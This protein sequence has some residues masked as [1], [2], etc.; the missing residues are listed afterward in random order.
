[1]GTVL[2]IALTFLIVNIIVD[3]LIAFI[4]P[5]IRLFDEGRLMIRSLRILAANPMSLVGV[6][7]VALVVLAAVLA[8]LIAPFPT[9]NG[10]VVDFI[11]ANQGPSARNW[12]G[13]DL[14]GRDIFSRILYAYQISLVLGVVV[15]AIAT[16]IGTVVGLLAG[17]LGGA[18][19]WGADA[20]HRRVPV[21]PAAGAGHR[22]DGRARADPD[23]RHAGG[24]RDVVALV[25]TPRLQHRPL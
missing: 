3:L 20:H 18:V 2:I 12:M 17:Y 4:N 5:K 1:M 13:T 14:V 15:L 7:L 8:P 16:P 21:D 6:F 19:R 25:C 9:H 11:Y 23:Q 22:H 24:H 10:A